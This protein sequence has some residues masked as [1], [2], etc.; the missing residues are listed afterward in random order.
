MMM[1]WQQSFRTSIQHTGDA[2]GSPPIA[3]ETGG[4]QYIATLVDGTVWA[5]KLGG[6]LPQRAASVWWARTSSLA[7][8]SSIRT[9]CGWKPGRACSQ[10]LWR[11]RGNHPAGIRKRIIDIGIVPVV[12][13]S[14]AAHALRGAETLCAGGIPIIEITM[15]VPGAIDLI[16]QLAKT[17]EATLVGAGTVLDAATAKRCYTE[18]LAA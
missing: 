4:E 15:T 5:F 2:G 14:S 7:N 8:M 16:A 12:R 18:M 17:G 1:S 6:T 10:A 13:L 3:F 9:V 11:P